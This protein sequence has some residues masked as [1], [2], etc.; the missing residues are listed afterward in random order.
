MT[1]S[2]YKLAIKEKSYFVVV[3]K[4]RMRF[5]NVKYVNM[6]SQSEKTGTEWTRVRANFMN[7]KQIGIIVYVYKLM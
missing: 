3:L 4:F 5:H 6:S 1:F 7:L 2:Y